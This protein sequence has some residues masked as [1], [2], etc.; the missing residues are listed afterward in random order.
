MGHRREAPGEHE[1]EVILVGRV[2]V[3]GQA[4]YGVLEGEQGARIDVELDVQVDRTTAAVLGVQVDL[5]GLAQGV[6]LDEVALVVDVEAVGD[7]VVLEIGD[8]TG[9]VD[10]GHR[11][12]VSRRLE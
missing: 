10:G 4:H 3:V 9:D 1:R 2:D 12:Q 5:P 11:P 7:R 6:G 8:E